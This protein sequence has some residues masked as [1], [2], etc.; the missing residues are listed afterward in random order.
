MRIIATDGAL[1]VKAVSGTHVVL[2]GLN[3]SKANCSGLLGFAIHRTDHTEDEAYWLKG[4]KRFQWA[5]DRYLEG[6]EVSTRF[7]PIQSFLWQDFTAKP[8]HEYT[9]RISEIL[10]DPEQSEIGRTISVKLRT[11]RQDDGT[12]RIFF[13]RGAVSS[14]KLK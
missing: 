7:H 9:Y 8:D 12:H 4:Q 2:L 11:E 3:L 13:N 5:D 1:S 10:G 6:R 14:Q